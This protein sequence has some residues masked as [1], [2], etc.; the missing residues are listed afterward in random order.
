MSFVEGATELK[1]KMNAIVLAHN[2]QPLEVQ[3]IADFVSDS[4]G[5]SLKALESKAKLIFYRS[6]FY[7]WTSVYSERECY[8]SLP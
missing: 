5:L 4:L 7:G 1:R 8:C 6:R 3:D 2:Y